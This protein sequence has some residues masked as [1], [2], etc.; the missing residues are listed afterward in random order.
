MIRQ[1]RGSPGSTNRNV[2][3]P[4]HAR[5]TDQE[6]KK[7]V[8]RHHGA[9]HIGYLDGRPW[10]LLRTA[11]RIAVP[12]QRQRIE[13]TGRGVQV[14]LRKVEVDGGLFQIAVAQQNLD[15]P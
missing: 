5:A 10:H 11:A 6:I 15:G 7:W 13:R 14:V 9:D 1:P 3:R 8:L 4:V 2:N 12:R